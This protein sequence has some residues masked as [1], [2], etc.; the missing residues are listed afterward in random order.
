MSY[1]NVHTTFYGDADGTVK[2][3]YFFPGLF[4]IFVFLIF[5]HCGLGF[6]VGVLDSVFGV[7]VFR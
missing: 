1:S 4:F 3:L 2:W 6:G 5:A 7:G